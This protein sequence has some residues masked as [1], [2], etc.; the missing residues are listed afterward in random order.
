MIDFACG[1]TEGK[2]NLSIGNSS[3]RCPGWRVPCARPV[4]TR[5]RLSA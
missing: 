1:G 5:R 2:P 3:R 4:A